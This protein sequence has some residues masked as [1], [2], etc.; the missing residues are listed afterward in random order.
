MG[1]FGLDLREEI[2]SDDPFEIGLVYYRGLDGVMVDYKKAF[3]WFLISDREGMASG[4]NALGK[5]YANGLYVER[6]FQESA[7]YFQRAVDRGRV[8]SYYFLAIAFLNLGRHARALDIAKEGIRKGVAKAYIAGGHVERAL[9]NYSSARKY[10]HRAYK[11]G[12]SEGAFFLGEFFGEGLG[13]QKNE[14][15]SNQWLLKA[16]RSG[17]MRAR[18][19]LRE[20]F[21]L[22]G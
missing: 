4:S 7:M 8:E 10:Y 2:K 11:R 16:S 21:E 19:L 5:M 12:V 14:Y 22:A 6:D 15:Y 18:N 3:S 17:D 13:C 20:G 9:E 1:L